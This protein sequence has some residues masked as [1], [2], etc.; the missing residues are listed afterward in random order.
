M[1]LMVSHVNTVTPSLPAAH[2][3]AAIVAARKPQ[4]TTTG[5]FDSNKM[6][7]IAALFA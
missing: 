6:I 3:V 4:A 5:T 2:N 7:N 1:R